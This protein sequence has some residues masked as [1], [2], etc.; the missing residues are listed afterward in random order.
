[1]R[2]A[3]SISPALCARWPAAALPGFFSEGGP[4]IASALIGQ[5]LADEIILFTAQK[6]LGRAGLPALDG[7]AL[8]ALEG[9]ARYDEAEIAH[10]GADEMRRFTRLFTL[11]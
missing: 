9:R 3:T 10:F 7:G 2:A 8:Q 11:A 4:R 6:P 5:D 1:M